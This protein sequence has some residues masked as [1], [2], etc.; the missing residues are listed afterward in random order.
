M[1]P[2]ESLYGRNCNTPVR[3]DNPPNREVVGREFLK[4]MEEKM[5]K[6][7]KNLKVSQKMQKSYADKN[8]THREF[9]VGDHLFLRV[10]ANISSLRLGNYSKLESGYC[11]PFKILERIGPIEYRIYFPA[12]MSI[13]NVFQVSFLKKY[14][15]DANHDIDWNVI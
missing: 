15:P 13:Y 3:W 4:E 6:I 1:S 8:K 9:K 5:L 11:G 12:C 7:M 10:K 14:L 2:F